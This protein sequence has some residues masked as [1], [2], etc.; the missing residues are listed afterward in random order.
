MVAPC[1]NTE[2]LHCMSSQSGLYS[3]V[4]NMVADK[5]AAR[6]ILRLCGVHKQPV[7]CWCGWLYCFM[8]LIRPRETFGAG[9]VHCYVTKRHP[10]P[11]AAVRRS[12]LQVTKSV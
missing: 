5:V 2:A 3:S 12:A 8:A 4:V 6:V 9:V 1:L 7:L 11:L 10:F